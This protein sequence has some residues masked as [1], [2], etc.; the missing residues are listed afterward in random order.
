MSIVYPRSSFSR[1]SSY[2]MH[3]ITQ[4]L[5]TLFL[6]FLT[7][8]ANLTSQPSLNQPQNIT[9]S[10]VS[11]FY[12][13][14][15]HRLSTTPSLVGLDPTNCDVATQFT[16]SRM[17][18]SLPESLIV[19]EKWIWTDEFPGCAIGY[20]L[21]TSHV[22]PSHSLCLLTYKDI[23][24]ECATNSSVNAGSVNVLEMPDWGQDGRAISDRYAMWIMAPER[25]TL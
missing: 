9:L 1:F 3:V 18:G 25:L 23:I 11:S 19:R 17:T 20:Y 4:I 12:G 21:H 5:P 14:Q 13:A 2:K 22:V 24:G 15:C 16:C 8:A 6:P 10:Q 7:F